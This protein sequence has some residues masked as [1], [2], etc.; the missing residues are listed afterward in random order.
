MDKLSFPLWIYVNE[1]ARKSEGYP[2]F[3][4]QRG[5][6]PTPLPG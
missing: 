5:G 4:L 6:P 3:L 1:H 2:Y